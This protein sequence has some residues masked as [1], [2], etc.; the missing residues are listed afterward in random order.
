MT[1]IILYNI[2]GIHV[3][4]P[5]SNSRSL[6]R[7]NGRDHGEN[8]PNFDASSCDLLHTVPSICHFGKEHNVYKISVF[9]VPTHNIKFT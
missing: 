2:L 8:K 3:Y 5:N 4:V 7:S 6:G 1:L 9:I